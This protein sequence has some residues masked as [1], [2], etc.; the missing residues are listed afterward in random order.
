MPVNLCRAAPECSGVSIHKVALPVHTLPGCSGLCHFTPP[1]WHKSGEPLPP[2]PPF[3]YVKHWAGT[4]V[5]LESQNKFQTDVYGY[6]GFRLRC[7]KLPVARDRRSVFKESQGSRKGRQLG[8]TSEAA[9]PSRQT[10]QGS[11]ARGVNTDRET[12]RL[13]SRQTKL[14]AIRRKQGPSEPPGAQADLG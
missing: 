9:H 11:S 6:T 10:G 3:L 14:V 8:D 12:K 7:P 4:L 1:I 13:R 5:H 2:I